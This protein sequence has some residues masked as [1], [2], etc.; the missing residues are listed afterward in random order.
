LATGFL[1]PH[2]HRRQGTDNKRLLD[3]IARSAESS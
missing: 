2:R 3:A 1:F